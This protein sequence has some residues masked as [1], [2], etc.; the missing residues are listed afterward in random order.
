[1]LFSELAIMMGVSYINNFVLV[2][3]RRN[4]KP[5]KIWRRQAGEDCVSVGVR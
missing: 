5:V 4:E 3:K 2:G 1:M